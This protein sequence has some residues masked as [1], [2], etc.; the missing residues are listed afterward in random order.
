MCSTALD[1]PWPPP[2]TPSGRSSQWVYSQGHFHYIWSFVFH[3]YVELFFQG[4]V[5][6]LL[7]TEMKEHIYFYATAILFKRQYFG[8]SDKQRGSETSGLLFAL[9]GARCSE[10]PACDDLNWIFHS[11][12]YPLRREIIA[13]LGI[14]FLSY[15]NLEDS[16][17]VYQISKTQEKVLSIEKFLQVFQHFIVSNS[18]FSF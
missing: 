16:D 5:Q 3:A 6:V 7:S 1:L 17:N 10:L 14:G 11:I 13:C 9:S 4:S 12:H 15:C 18:F 2:T 8:L